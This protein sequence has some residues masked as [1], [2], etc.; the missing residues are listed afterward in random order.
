MRS[1]SV[2]WNGHS[3]EDPRVSTSQIFTTNAHRTSGRHGPREQ[4]RCHCVTVTR[5]EKE[6]K[7]EGQP[8]HDL[9]A[10]AKCIQCM[11]SSTDGFG[12]HGVELLFHIG[13]Q[14]PV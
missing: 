8:V 4:E 3:S 5:E 13:F 1:S 6:E 10:D 7:Q 9:N 11:D 12:L 14:G 2:V